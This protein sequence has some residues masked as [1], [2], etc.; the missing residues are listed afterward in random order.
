MV[1]Q[2]SLEPSALVRIQEGQPILSST[3]DYERTGDVPNVVFSCGIIPEDDGTLKIYYGAGDT[4]LCL[5]TTKIADLVKSCSGSVWEGKFD[6]LPL[7]GPSATGSIK[8]CK[9]TTW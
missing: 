9:S 3:K 1:G 2:R 6:N 5:A 8:L 4:G 7:G